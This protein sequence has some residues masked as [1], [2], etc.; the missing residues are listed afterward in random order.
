MG[1][2]WSSVRQCR[3]PGLWGSGLA[4][5][6]ALTWKQ[7]QALLFLTRHEASMP[8]HASAP[9]LVTLGGFIPPAHAGSTGTLRDLLLQVP[10]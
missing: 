4:T 5:V 9:T 7:S 8:R 1:T 3:A 6:V 2:A 10:Y